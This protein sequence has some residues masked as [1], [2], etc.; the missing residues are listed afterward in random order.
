[1]EEVIKIKGRIYILNYEKTYYIDEKKEHI[2]PS[3]PAI[4]CLCLNDTFQI[5]YDEYECWANCKCGRRFCI[6]SG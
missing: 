3:S 5:N 2:Y 4:V 6:Y 1:M